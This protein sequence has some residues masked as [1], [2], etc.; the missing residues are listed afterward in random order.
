MADIELQAH[1]I[2]I[3]K[4]GLESIIK[5]A[6]QNSLDIIALLDYNSYIFPELITRALSLD[7]KYNVTFN[8]EVIKISDDKKDT[9]FL[10]GLELMTKEKIQIISLGKGNFKETDSIIDVIKQKKL[11]ILDHPFV[12]AT[13]ATRAVNDETNAFIEHLSSKYHDKIAYEWNAYCLAWIW[14]LALGGDINKRMEKAAEKYNIPVVADDDLHGWK[15]NLMQD[16]G[17]SRVRINDSDLDFNIN[18]LIPSIED[19][20]LQKKHEN[21]KKYVSNLHFFN[22]FAVPI[23]KALIM[24]KLYPAARGKVKEK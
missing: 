16:L 13:C 8:E 20:I 3:K 14:N 1:P 19:A 10:N 12:D 6:H 9:Y 4:Y 17:K 24:Q 15:E 7:K 11:T 18:Y 2:G 22:A 23:G 5:I 21:I